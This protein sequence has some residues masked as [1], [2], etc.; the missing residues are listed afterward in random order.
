M[1][2]RLKTLRLNSCVGP[3]HTI[4]YTYKNSCNP[5][6]AWQKLFYQLDWADPII[7]KNSKYNKIDW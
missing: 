2:L 4:D 7:K 5:F 1:G 6:L 3:I